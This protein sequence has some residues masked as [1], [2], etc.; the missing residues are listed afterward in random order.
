MHT[1]TITP[2]AASLM[3]R[4]APQAS[5]QPDEDYI[6]TS[7]MARMLGISQRRAIA[8]C[9]EGVLSE[10]KDWW[11]LPSSSHNKASNGRRGGNYRIKR[12]SVLKL[13]GGAQ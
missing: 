12:S 10:V 8:I 3:A 13:K 2:Y 7:E 9:D 6:S 11:R 5:P 4:G 1:L